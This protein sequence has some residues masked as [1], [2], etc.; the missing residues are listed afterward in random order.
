M[1]R[2]VI[3]SNRVPSLRERAQ[4]A[5]GLAIALKDAIRGRDTLWLG[6]SGNQVPGERA[7]KAHRTRGSGVQFATV[8]L[9]EAQYSGFYQGFSNGALWPLMHGR[10]GL[11]DFSRED[12]AAY[13]EVNALFADALV[14]LLRPD[15][16]IWV[17]DYHLIPFGQALRTRGVHNRVGFFLHIPFPPPAVFEILPQSDRLLRS[18]EAYDLIG[19]QTEDDA[20]H[21]NQALDANGV[22]ARA[23]AY[24]IGIDPAAFRKA[25]EAAVGGP[26]LVRL[27]ESLA[28]RALILGVD[29]LDYSKGLPQRFRGYARLLKR[30]PEHRNKVV[31]MQVAPVSRGDVAQYRSLRRELDELAGRINGESAEFDW[32]PLHYITRALARDTLAGFHRR[33][34]VGLVTPL[35]DGMN[36]V[37]KEYVAAQDPADPGVLVLSRFAGAAAGMKGAIVVNPYDPDEIAEALHEALSLP[38]AERLG[39]WRTLEDAVERDTA[40]AWAN[41]FMA[42]LEGKAAQAA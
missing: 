12:L 11:A 22:P 26:E 13:L 15:D 29:R 25:A 10:T 1:G 7:G 28:G 33:A 8:D 36:L 6:W 39:R 37:A 9:T 16:V 17:H 38:L 24:P 23:H 19:V 32:V 2:L 5:G 35:R 27:D 41:S 40:S 30:F 3:V 4:L 31:F 21:L 20:R 42:A 18:F 14:P 34:R